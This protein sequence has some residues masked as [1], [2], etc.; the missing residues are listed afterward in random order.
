[1]KL[2][3]SLTGSQLEALALSAGERLIYC[4]PA[5]LA[6]EVRRAGEMQTRGGLAAAVL[7]VVVA[8]GC[9]TGDCARDSGT[10]D[11]CDDGS[12]VDAYTN[13]LN[14]SKFHINA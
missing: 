5:D 8:S 2:L 6:Y 10:I 14:Q 1:M 3:F 12:G 13:R 7:C 9:C 11:A 4:V